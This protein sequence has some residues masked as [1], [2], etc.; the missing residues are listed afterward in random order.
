M[1]R[2]CKRTKR[3]G[4]TKCELLVE[5]FPRVHFRVASVLK[6]RKRRRSVIKIRRRKERD[7]RDGRDG[8]RRERD[9]RK[10][11]MERVKEYLSKGNKSL[12]RY[13]FYL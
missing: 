6:K 9:F 3:Y 8:K 12:T 13:K 10:S 1:I 4:R 11:L 5:K 2:G 7:E